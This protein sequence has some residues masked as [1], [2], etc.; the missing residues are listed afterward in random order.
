MAKQ[1]PELLS[2]SGISGITMFFC[3]AAIGAYHVRTMG[4]VEVYPYAFVLAVPFMTVVSFMFVSALVPRLYAT[5]RL[6]FP[7][8]VSLPIIYCLLMLVSTVL[9]SSTGNSL[10]RPNPALDVLAIWFSP[11]V[12]LLLAV[13]QFV[14]LTLVGKLIR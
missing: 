9:W 11:T 13:I 6:R 12:L 14:A 5:A 4:A 10:V 3:A 1:E 7:L 2:L 8:T